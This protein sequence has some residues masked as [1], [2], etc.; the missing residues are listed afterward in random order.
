MIVWHRKRSKITQQM[1]A[2]LADI[3]RTAVQRLESGIAP[4]QVDTLWKVLNVLNIKMG[5]SGPLMT[6]YAETLITPPIQKKSTAPRVQKKS[7]KK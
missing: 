4:V 2:D 7:G 3:S 6:R 5:Y 1:L